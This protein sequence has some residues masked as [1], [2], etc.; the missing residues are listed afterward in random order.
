MTNEGE[1]F[2]QEVRTAPFVAEHKQITDSSS[3]LYE[4]HID[5]NKDIYIQD[6]VR[7][8]DKQIPV[9]L[10]SDAKDSYICGII[11]NI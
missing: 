1:I 2:S 8:L 7:T 6:M 10:D 11:E 9:T 5:E 4:I 3:N